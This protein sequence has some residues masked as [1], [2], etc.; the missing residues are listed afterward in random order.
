[1]ATPTSKVVRRLRKK[2]GITVYT[3]NDFESTQ[4]RTY[5][6]RRLQRPVRVKCADTVVQHITVTLDTGPLTGDFKRDVLTVE[7]IGTER[8][9]SGI[10]YNF[11]VDMKTGEVAVGQPLDAK[12]THTV[13][14]K[15][16]PG[17]SKDQ[18]HAAR[19]IAVL[20]MPG[21]VLSDTAA[22]S[23][24]AILAALMDTKNITTTFDYLP[25]SFFT[26]K[27]CP[28]DSTRDRM[29]EIRKDAFRLRKHVNRKKISN[30]VTQARE[31]LGEALDRAKRKRNAKRVEKIT[32]GLKNLPKQ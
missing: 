16:V 17:Y 21:D 7:R 2:Y 10:S 14:D 13:N 9:G 11:I 18:N 28:C 4:K 25:H 31:L 1:M 22:R 29:P 3:H 20:G 8:F 19:A 12:G 5:A 27:D 6:L 30:R 23:I 32:K 26:W 24:A 15:N